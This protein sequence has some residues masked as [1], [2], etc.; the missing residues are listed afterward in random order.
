M[1]I[2]KVICRKLKKKIVFCWRLEGNDENSRFRTISQRHESATL[3][4]TLYSVHYTV[5]EILTFYSEGS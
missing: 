5:I 1:Y 4:S 3:V 2:Q